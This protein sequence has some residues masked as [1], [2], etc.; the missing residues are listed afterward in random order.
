MKKY[1]LAEQAAMLKCT[2]EQLLAQHEKN[3]AGLEQMH[4][5][6][7]MTGRKVNGYTAAM[8][9]ERITARKTLIEEGRK[10]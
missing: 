10:S 5:K 4:A 2:R 8:L 3:L 9:E 1:T 6:A 7:V